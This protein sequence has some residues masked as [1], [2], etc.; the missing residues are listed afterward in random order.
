MHVTRITVSTLPTNISDTQDVPFEQD[1]ADTLTL[2]FHS[3]K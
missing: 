1:G 3:L 2:Y